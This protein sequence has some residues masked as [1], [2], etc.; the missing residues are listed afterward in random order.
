[1]TDNKRALMIRATKWEA[2]RHGADGKKK[3]AAM[4]RGFLKH[5]CLVS[6]IHLCIIPTWNKKRQ[7]VP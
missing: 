6:S 7:I 4:P 3:F 1:M 5:E 2:A